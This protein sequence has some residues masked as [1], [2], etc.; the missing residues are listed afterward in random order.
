MLT[1]YILGSP[2]VSIHGLALRVAQPFTNTGLVTDLFWML[3]VPV[4][5]LAILG[6]RKLSHPV[7]ITLTAILLLHS[8]SP[9]LTPNLPFFLWDR[10]MY[11]LAVPF[12]LLAGAGLVELSELPGLKKWKYALVGMCTFFASTS[13]I[14]FL[15]PKLHLIAAT[16]T[17][18]PE[19]VDYFPPTF[20]WNAIGHEKSS[21]LVQA[22]QA[23]HDNYDGIT[24]IYTSAPYEGFVWYYLPTLAP[25]ITIADTPDPLWSA[26][27]KRYYLYGIDYAEIAEG[28]QLPGSPINEPVRL[29]DSTRP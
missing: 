13:G 3:Y 22:A 18:Q 20:Q 12:G 25:S 14:H 24:A 6:L 9:I 19:L 29:Y 10:W 7:F 26:P 17:P 5:P 27:A 16:P 28:T 21:D 1:L 11:F 4:L 23:L 2:H 8:F 15:M